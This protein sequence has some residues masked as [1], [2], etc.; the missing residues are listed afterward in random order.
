LLTLLSIIFIRNFSEALFSTTNEFLALPLI[1]HWTSIYICSFL[2]AVLLITFLSKERVEKVSKITL[3]GFVVIILPPFIEYLTGNVTHYNYIF[4]SNVPLS[5]PNWSLLGTAFVTFY[6]NVTDVMLGQKVELIIFI[7][8]ASLYVFVK[9]RSI[10]R[11]VI[12]ALVMYA[13]E[14]FYLSFPNYFSFGTLPDNFDFS[15]WYGWIYYV[16]L[17]A[18]LILL[19]GIIC[20]YLYN[21]GLTKRLIKNLLRERTLHYLAFVWF[22][23]LLAAAG[24]YS[25]LLASICIALLWQT[26]V[27]I[28][29]VFDVE[30]DSFSKKTNPLVEGTSNTRQM[31]VIAF[32][33][34]FLS[35]YV[36]T[37]LSYSAAMIA[38]FYIVLSLLYSMPPFRLKKIPI[39]SI[40]VIAAEILLAFALGFYSESTSVVFPTTIA[41]TIFLCFFFAAHTK[42][43]KDYD[44]DKRTG[45][46]TIPVLFGMERG[47]TI[48]GV[49]NFIAYLIVPFM[50]GLQILIIPA[51]AFGILTFFVV[52]RPQSR[53]WQIFLLYFL[54]LAV[55]FFFVINA[56]PP[57][58]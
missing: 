40:V 29:D 3:L 56:Y 21:H 43:L 7:V 22:G 16:S 31:S 26:N 13:L 51:V 17:F 42:D 1:H 53:E 25:V 19:Q 47:R 27:A 33:C 39:I 9:T 55:V 48:I 58:V 36:A 8:L 14:F 41:Y 52:K 10:L 2:S 34:A 24:W 38:F 45:V 57:T 37:F 23:A 12:M 50:L 18:L 49:L 28:N 30:G 32:A 6:S 54:Y 44:G 20:L 5:S 4:D 11:T 35:I 15:H 46:L